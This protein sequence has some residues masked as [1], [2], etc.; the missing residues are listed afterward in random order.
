MH[1][2]IGTSQD[3][4]NEPKH[5]CSQAETMSKLHTSRIAPS[6]WHTQTSKTEDDTKQQDKH[7]LVG[8]LKKTRA[9]SSAPSHL[10]HFNMSGELYSP[11]EEHRPEALLDMSDQDATLYEQDIT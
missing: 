6:I 4:L 5:S 10:R 9:D 2:F 8:T 11:M 3:R 7:I 1:N